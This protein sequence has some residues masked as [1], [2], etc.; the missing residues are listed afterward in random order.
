MVAVDWGG[1]ILRLSP[2]LH[3]FYTQLVEIS[4]AQSIHLYS[5]IAD[6]EAVPRTCISKASEALG[7]I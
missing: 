1:Q 7:S 2:S 4:G 5:L 6:T 3:P